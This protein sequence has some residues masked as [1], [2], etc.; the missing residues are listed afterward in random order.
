MHACKHSYTCTHT[1]TYTHAHTHAHTHTTHTHAH[2][3]ARTHAHKH[4][5]G[6][7]AAVT[8]AVNGW[9][10]TVGTRRWR[11]GVSHK[12]R[13]EGRRGLQLS[14]AVPAVAAK[15]VRA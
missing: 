12:I 2:T 7:L 13:I 8:M 15:R 5:Q 11:K 6:V 10:R 4:T 3:H 9:T 1:H 14:Q